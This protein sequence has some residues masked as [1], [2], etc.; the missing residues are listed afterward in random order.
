M[1]ASF[2]WNDV[3]RSFVGTSLLL[4]AML[5]TTVSAYR[6]RSLGRSKTSNHGVTREKC[7]ADEKESPGNKLSKIL[8]HVSRWLVLFIL[9]ISSCGVSVKLSNCNWTLL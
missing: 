9:G 8:S 6:S 2:G 4:R 3:F 5:A 7:G 1:Q